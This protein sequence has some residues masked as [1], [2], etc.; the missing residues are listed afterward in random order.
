MNMLITNSFL[1]SNDPV[2]S[3]DHDSIMALCLCHCQAQSQILAAGLF[4]MV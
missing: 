2:Q 3:H 4:D 1:G